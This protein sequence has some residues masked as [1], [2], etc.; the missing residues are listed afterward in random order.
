MTGA[1]WPSSARVVR[2]WVKSRNERNP[3]HKLLCL[4][5]P[6]GLTRRK[7]GMTSGQHGPYT[8]GYTRPTMAVTKRLPS[9]KAERIASKAA[10]V[11]IEG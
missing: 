10:S 8:S 4:M 6:P 7:V 9:R 1:A 11:R 2:C 3:H 5:R